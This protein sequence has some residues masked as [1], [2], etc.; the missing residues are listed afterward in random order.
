MQAI[1]AALVPKRLQKPDC[2]PHL[3]INNQKHEFQVH[4]RQLLRLGSYRPIRSRRSRSFANARTKASYR[5]LLC[6]RL[7]GGGAVVL[8]VHFVYS[9]GVGLC[10]MWLG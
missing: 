4:R 7:E 3:G 2:Y 6:V 8:M 1:A 5:L 9:R 10:R